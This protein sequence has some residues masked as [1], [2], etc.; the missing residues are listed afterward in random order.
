[1]ENCVD[2]L[3][4]KYNQILNICS[5]RYQI[6][7]KISITNH[8]S[9]QYEQSLLP[10][11]SHYPLSNLFNVLNLQLHETSEDV[12]GSKSR[13]SHHMINQIDFCHFRCAHTNTKEERV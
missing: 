6:V 9:G 1:M 11:T 7:P 13:D 5:R 8:A 10:N 4:A 2:A 3:C 12:Y